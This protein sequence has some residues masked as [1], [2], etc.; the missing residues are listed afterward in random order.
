MTTLFCRKSRT[1]Y[2]EI[3]AASRRPRVLGN[4][5]DTECTYMETSTRLDIILIGDGVLGAPVGRQ[6]PESSDGRCVCPELKVLLLAVVS[7]ARPTCLK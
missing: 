2:K 5:P 4:D 3:L 6:D 7:C 1:H